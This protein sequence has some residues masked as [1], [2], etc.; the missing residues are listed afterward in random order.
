[1]E[2]EIMD[3]L[4]KVLE[5]MGAKMDLL[6]IVGSYKSSLTDEKVLQYLREWIICKESKTTST[7]EHS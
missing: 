2:K 4:Y 3:E 7:L 1:M 5:I 6:A